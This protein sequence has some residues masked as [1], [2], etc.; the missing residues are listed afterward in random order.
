MIQA[1]LIPIPRRMARQRRSRIRRW[2]TGCSAYSFLLLAGFGAF[3]AV[4]GRDD[5]VLE[6]DVVTLTQEIAATDME[7]KAVTPR[8][9]DA[10]LTLAASEAVGS[11]PNWSVLLALL[12]KETREEHDDIHAALE[13]ALDAIGRSPLWPHRLSPVVMPVVRESTKQIVL[14][15]CELVPVSAPTAAGT[16][17]KANAAPSQPRYT[18]SLTGVGRSQGAISRHVL[19]LERTGLF[20]RV[21]L[22]ESKLAPFAGGEA[23]SFRIACTLGGGGGRAPGVAEAGG[24]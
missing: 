16:D 20:D 3:Q 23:V 19:R 24:Q 1:N 13:Q 18:L 9:N 14:S 11:Q 12:A 17:L 2:L 10:R 8:L 21:T 22:I 7:V 15:S 5:L 4:T 6:Q